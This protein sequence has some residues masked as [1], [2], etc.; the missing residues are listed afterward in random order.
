MMIPSISLYPMIRRM[1]NSVSREVML[2]IPGRE[3]S[4]DLFKG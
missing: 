3:A 1:K 4:G 2:V